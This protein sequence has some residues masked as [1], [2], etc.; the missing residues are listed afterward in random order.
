MG[1][2]GVDVQVGSL[3]SLIVGGIEFDTVLDG[4]A[5]PLAKVGPL[6]EAGTS[7]P[8]YPSKSALAQAQFTQ[9][10]PFMVYFDGSVRGLHAGAPVEFRGI[11]VGR[12]TS[13]ALDYNRQTETMRIPVGLEIEPQ[14]LD[15]TGFTAAELVAKNRPTMTE[16]VKRGLRAQLQSGNLLTGELFVDLTFV[17]NAQPAELDISGPVPVIPSVPGTFDALQASVTSILNKVASLP[18]E[19]LI[20]SLVGTAQ[21]LEGIVKSPDVKQASQSLNAVLSQLQ[22]TVARVDNAAGPLLENV[23]AAAGTADATL[24]DARLAIAS[25][26]RSIGSGSA[27]TTNAESMIQELSRAARSIRVFAD[28]LDRHPDALLRGKTDGGS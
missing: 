11:P 27:L 1:A 3:Q 14:R 4:N 26:Q 10:I 19:D 8:L 15:P 5:G 2:S 18:L 21:G 17:A 28:Y 12:V 20:A 9:K 13:V 7:F 6:A 23:T 24:R 16:M 25:L 22:Q